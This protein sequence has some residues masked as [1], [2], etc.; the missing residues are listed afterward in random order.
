MANVSWGPLKALIVN[1]EI[2][3]PTTCHYCSKHMYSSVDDALKVAKLMASKG[4]KNAQV[5]K[6]KKHPEQGWH[7]TSGY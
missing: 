7:L 6:C 5:Y 2:R 3:Y 1:G 4:T